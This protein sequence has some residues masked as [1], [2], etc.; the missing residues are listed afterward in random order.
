MEKSIWNYPWVTVFV[1]AVQTVAGITLIFDIPF[2]R[3]ISGFFF[4]FFIPGFVLLRLFRMEKI[5]LAETILFSVGLSLAFL[6]IIGFLINELGSFNLISKPLSLEPLAIII[7]ITVTLMAILSHFINKDDFNILDAITLKKLKS[8][9]FYFFI[10]L[11]SILGVLVSIT[12]NNNLLLIS[13][14]IVLPI[15]FVSSLISSKKTSHY[16]LLILIIALVL[17]LSFTLSSRYI[18]GTDI[19]FEYS[20]FKATQTFSSLNWQPNHFEQMAAKSM[21]SVTILPTIFSNLLN[22]EGE[23][24]FKVIIPIIFSLVPVGLYLFYQKHWGKRAAFISVIFFVSN[25]EFSNLMTTNAKPMIGE[26]FYILLFLIM[27]NKRGN[28]TSGKW[29]V[30]IFFIFGLAL[31]HY[32]LN[33][34]FISL[35]LLTVIFGKFLLKNKQLIIN[36]S[37][38]AFSISMTFL[39][40]INLVQGPFTKL[41]GVIESTFSHL[42]TDFFNISSR[43]EPLQVAFGIIESPTIFHSMGRYMFNIAILLIFIGF[44]SLLLKWRRDKFDSEYVL[45]TSL[46]MGLMFA[47][48]VV[49]LFAGFLEIGRLYQFALLFLAPL[50][51]LGAETLFMTFLNL[52]KRKQHVDLKNKKKKKNICLILT[53]I[54]LVTFFLFSTGFIYE[55]TGDPV[56]SSFAL[57]KDKLQDSPILILESDVF[58]ARW[59]SEYG[60][61]KYILTYS[62]TLS[63]TNVL[64]SYSYIERPMLRIISNNTLGHPA[65]GPEPIQPYIANM[66][67]VYLGKL[68]VQHEIINYDPWSGISFN[69]SEVPILNSTNFFVNRIYSNSASEIYYRT[70]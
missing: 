50:F 15:V 20:A 66:S 18:Y 61:V 69:F 54:V 47:A 45:I 51:A 26:L 39:W 16:P 56:P 57:S 4:L 2:V 3:Q 60:G 59:L 38:L 24:V 13:V 65:L 22:I 7:N 44:I 48:L 1:L 70:P 62:D 6:M 33:Y 42:L 28:N 34:L 32:S 21:L 19:Q 12:L 29:V 67:Y 27:L 46:N 64:T 8:S 55:I 43:G 31:S 25:Y 52:N 68:N 49:P 35:I 37:I 30:T 9:I 23:W 63:L 17:L 58:S 36:P 40:Y 11:L 41:V 53:S 10:L 14:F 5:N